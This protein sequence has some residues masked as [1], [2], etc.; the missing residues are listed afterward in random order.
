MKNSSEEW[1]KT[2]EESNETS[3]EWNDKSEEFFI[4][5]VGVSKQLPR[6]FEFPQE[7]FGESLELRCSK[8]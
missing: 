7:Q 4:S 3:E 1:N 5:Y 8:L 2:S 6:G